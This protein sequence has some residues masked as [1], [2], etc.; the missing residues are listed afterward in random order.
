MAYKLIYFDM[1]GRAETSRFIFAQAGVAYEDCR[2]AYNGEEWKKLKPTTPTGRLPVLE[3]DGKPLTGSKPINRFLAERFGLAGSNDFENA[4]LASIVDVMSDFSDKLA[5]LYR[6]QD[7]ERKPALKKKIEDEAIPEYFSILEKMIQ[8]N[9]SE[10][11]WSF[12]EK[13]T[14]ADFN[15]YC[16]VE[17]TMV[18]FPSVLDSYPGIA[19]LKDAVEA[20]PNIAN[21][22]KERPKTHH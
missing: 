7:E 5:V 16:Y 11:D 8:K 3:V 14:Y 15:I 2:I 10:G 6:E 12:G 21:W 17:C 4:Q 18:L 19:K 22:I 1:Q 13:P 9:G 20:L